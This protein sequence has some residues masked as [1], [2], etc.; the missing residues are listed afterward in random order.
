MRCVLSGLGCFVFIG[1]WLIWY[2]GFIIN[3]LSYKKKI[4]TTYLALCD[5]LAQPSVTR[6]NH[7]A[8]VDYCALVTLK[9]PAIKDE[10]I[11][12][13]HY[14]NY[15]KYSRTQAASK[16]HYR[17]IKMLAKKLLNKI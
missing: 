4:D 13:T 8:T 6:A 3:R 1:F 7:I 11:E 16:D 15:L 17:K 10:M 5:R 2:A 12:F 14:Y 9:M